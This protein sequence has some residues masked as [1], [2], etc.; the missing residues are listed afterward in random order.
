M[1]QLFYCVPCPLEKRHFTTCLLTEVLVKFHSNRTLFGKNMN[2]NVLCNL[3]TME[4]QK[5]IKSLDRKQ[6]CLLG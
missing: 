5:G 1:W 3:R 6:G 4:L 2:L